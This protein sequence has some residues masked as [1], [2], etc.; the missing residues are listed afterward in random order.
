[1]ERANAATQPLAC[2]AKPKTKIERHLV[3]PAAGCVKLRPCSSY[4]LRKLRLYV[5]VHILEVLAELKFP[6]LDVGAD[7]EQ[8]CFDLAEF[9]RCE[10]VRA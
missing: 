9:L 3:V 5:H 2:V 10:N 1:M 6:R 7:F 4:A 8:A